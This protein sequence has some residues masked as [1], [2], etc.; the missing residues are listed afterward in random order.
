MATKKACGVLTTIHGENIDNKVV[1]TSSKKYTDCFQSRV[2]FER[3]WEGCYPMKAIKN[4]RCYFHSL[5]CG[6]SCFATIR[7][8]LILRNIKVSCFN[9][10][11]SG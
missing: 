11:G 5:P 4:E 3:E 1:E 9:Q 8:D 7:E 6:K 10:M 2:L